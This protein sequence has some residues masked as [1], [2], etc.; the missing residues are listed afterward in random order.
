MFYAKIFSFHRLN[1]LDTKS[2]KLS[3][4][5]IASSIETGPVN[6]LANPLEEAEP[7]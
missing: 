6:E 1:R 2:V 7:P 4:T 3:Y 5:Y